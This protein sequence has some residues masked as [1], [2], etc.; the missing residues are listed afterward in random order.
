M[1]NKAY[2]DE[3]AVKGKKK[4]TGPILTPLMIKLIITAVAALVT[5]VTVA[6]FIN[7]KN[8]ENSKIDQ[9]VYARIASLLDSGG[10]MLSY[11]DDLRSA[12]LRGYTTNL[13]NSLTTAQNK[14]ASVASAV[15]VNPE[16]F[17]QDVI[18]KEA[19]AMSEFSSELESAK[20]NGRIDRA[21]AINA[22]YQITLL[23]SL[24]EQARGKATNSAYA[25]ALDN[26]LSDL[27]LIYNSFKNYNDTY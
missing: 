24:E 14:L 16:S 20:L 12:E 23:I 2:L 15:N 26:S 10:P 11:Q 18:D 4:N 8:I 19:A 1:D 6:L 27:E 22:A 13:V 3:I 25:S 7:S 9:Q 5:I 17:H 21:F